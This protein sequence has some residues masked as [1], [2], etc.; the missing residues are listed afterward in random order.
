VQVG[1]EITSG[2]LWPAGKVSGNGGASWSQLGQLMI[3]AVQGIRDASGAHMPKIIVHIDRGGDWATTMWFFDNLTA[4]GVPFDIIGESYYTFFQGSP[5]SLSN[6]LNNAAARYG[7]PI[8]VA[9]DAF[10]WTNSC[11]SSWTNS[12]Y[13]YAPT[14]DGQVSFIAAIAQIV[15]SV[16][17]Q[18]G[19]GF[20]YW[21]AEYQ[22]AWGVNE[23]GYNTSSFFDFS[24]NVLP[25][26]DAV[27]GMAAPLLLSPV[28]DGSYLRLQWPFS[29]A[30]ATLLTT[31]NLGA[32]GTWS[33]VNGTVQTTG[34]VFTVT[35]PIGNK[36]CFYRLGL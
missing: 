13:G 2:M 20:F 18:L 22:A 36:V 12:L 1:N 15:K 8:I 16:P 24:G 29:G 30:G 32:S 6:C 10:P 31:T 27:A 34:A 11:P 4:Q 23:A 17:N 3:A 26:A 35:L 7:K 21:G 5:E 14:V 33:A 19:A 25:V 9:E 28:V